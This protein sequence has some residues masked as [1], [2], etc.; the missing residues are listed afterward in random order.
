MKLNPNLELHRMCLSKRRYETLDEIRTKAANI[1]RSHSHPWSQFRL[2]AYEC[3][4]CHHYHLTKHPRPLDSKLD[5]RV[6][7]PLD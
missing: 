1:R 3:P 6:N 5:D 2:Y 7:I 4:Y